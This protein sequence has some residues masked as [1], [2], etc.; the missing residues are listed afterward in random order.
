MQSGNWSKLESYG[1]S[2]TVKSHDTQLRPRGDHV[3]PQRLRLT[4]KRRAQLLYRDPYYN[5]DLASD[6][7]D[8]SISVVRAAAVFPIIMIDGLDRL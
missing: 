5:P 4:R 3:L 8:F 6:P 1:P 7:E 2:S